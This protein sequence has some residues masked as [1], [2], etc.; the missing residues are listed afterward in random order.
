MHIRDFPLAAQHPSHP[1]P[2]P[3]KPQIELLS[4]WRRKEGISTWLAVKGSERNDLGLAELL[5]FLSRNLGGTGM[6]CPPGLK[7]LRASQSCEYSHHQEC[8][9]WL[10]NGGCS[11]THCSRVAAPLHTWSDV[12]GQ[13]GKWE[14]TIKGP[15]L[16]GQARLMDSKGGGLMRGWTAKEIGWLAPGR[17]EP[18]ATGDKGHRACLFL[19]PSCSRPC[20]VLRANER[21]DWPLCAGRSRIFLPILQISQLRLSEG[22]PHKQRAL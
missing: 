22:K 18:D 7:D 13:E 3:K 4:T 20:F 17:E 12:C 21:W 10:G 11:Q 14:S 2:P 6:P 9:S 5:L 19:L 8:P 16:T 15:L 1:T